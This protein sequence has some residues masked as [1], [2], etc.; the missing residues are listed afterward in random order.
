MVR[1]NLFTPTKDLFGSGDVGFNAEIESG[2]RRWLAAGVFAV[3]VA[4]LV[5]RFRRR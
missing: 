4:I 5:W 2:I 1:R 3:V